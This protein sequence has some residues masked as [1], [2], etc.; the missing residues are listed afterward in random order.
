[1]AD[2]EIDVKMYAVYFVFIAILTILVIRLV[3]S[4]DTTQSVIFAIA[5]IIS[6]FL[7]VKVVLGMGIPKIPLIGKKEVDSGKD[8]EEY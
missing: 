5:L 8:T 6:L 4:P 7:F 3:K 1:M 2:D